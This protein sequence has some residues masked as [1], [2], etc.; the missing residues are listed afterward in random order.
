M[1]KEILSMKS[2]NH[3]GNFRK[4]LTLAPN[5][6]L[7]PKSNGTF[8]IVHQ[9]DPIDS[10]IYTALIYEICPIIEKY[11]IPEDKHIACSY[12]IKPS[13]AG[14]FFDKNQ[15]GWDIFTSRTEELCKAYSDGFVISCDITDFYNQIYLHRV[16]NSIAEAGETKFDVYAKIVEAFLTKLNKG[17]SRGIPVGPAPSIILAEAIM[18]DI[19]NKILKH[20]QDFTR[21][22]DDIRIFFKTESEA[23]EALHELTRYL[24]SSHRLVLSGEKTNIYDVATFQ[25]DHFRVVEKDEETEIVKR[26]ETEAFA[27]F[28]EI[29]S[30]L[31][32][33]AD[34]SDVDYDEVYAQIADEKQFE[35][36]S[37]TYKEIFAKCIAKIPYDTA[38]LR[39]ILRKAAL[40]R[41]RSI[42]KLVLENFDILISL[43][44]EVILYLLKTTNNE[45]INEYKNE[46]LK[47][48][49]SPYANLPFV[50]M[51]L[52]YLFES[53]MFRQHEIPN[54]AFLHSIRSKAMHAIRDSDRIWVKDY[55]DGI[56]TLGVW[57]RRSVIY[58]SSLLS[59]DEMINWLKPISGRGDIVDIS[60]AGY[61]KSCK[62]TKAADE[63]E[64]LV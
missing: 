40:Y 37:Q 9:L 59:K 34:P 62:E 49:I 45:S 33:Y 31:P 2:E 57:D 11:R 16:R 6:Y 58:A 17:T 36:L 47:L 41:I 1:T 64:M 42:Y 20:T 23:I 61:L 39:H 32:D 55:R 26:T 56:D 18:A 51:W 12:R 43:I 28:E 10:I 22:V 5:I 19:D 29:L 60:L 3:E 13:I 53:E 14:S 21:Y 4:A 44:R 52:C 30:D 50:N 15:N 63:I 8:R 46:F 38:L 54:R 25:T 24:H 35:I 7:A 48:L 27:R